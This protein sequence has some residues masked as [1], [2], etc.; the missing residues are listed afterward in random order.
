MSFWSKLFSR[1]RQPGAGASRIAPR[2]DEAEATDNASTFQLLGR[3]RSRSVKTIGK[4]NWLTTLLAGGIVNPFGPTLGVLAVDGLIEEGKTLPIIQL[5]LHPLNQDAMEVGSARIGKTWTPLVDLPPFFSLPFIS[6]CPT[7]L[8]PSCL[9]GPDEVLSI[10]SRFLATFEDGYSVLEK[11]RRFPGD[12]RKRVRQDIR[13]AFSRRN[14]DEERKE[15]NAVE[16]K[17]L[18]SNLLN[19]KNLKEEI[20]AFC[21]A[22]KGSIEHLSGPMASMPYE[23]F[24]KYFGRLAVFCTLPEMNK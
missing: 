9:M 13:D 14:A 18:A 2:A 23:E 7:L 24:M 6:Y 3:P 16:A 5:M 17:E 22:W 1:E 8:L 21:Y 19:P 12:P 4:N 10:Y 20:L 11:V 15:L